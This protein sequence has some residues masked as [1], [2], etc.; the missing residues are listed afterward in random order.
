M[1]IHATL[2]RDQYI[3][4]ALWRH[5]SRRLFFFYA[6]TTAFVTAYAMVYETYIFLLVGWIPFG[7]YVLFGFVDVF[8]N[9][10]QDTQPALQPTQY[11]FDKKSVS[12]KMGESTSQLTWDDFKNWRTIADCYVLVLVNGAVLAIPKIDVPLQRVKKFEDLLNEQIKGSK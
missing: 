3:R 7:L 10:R 4:I 6:A 1:N 8:R 2:Q 11:K 9:S 12:V 5:F